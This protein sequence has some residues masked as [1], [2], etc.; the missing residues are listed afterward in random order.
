[1]QKEGSR[2]RGSF[3]FFYASIIGIF[4]PTKH[5]ILFYFQK[6]LRCKGS[7]KNAVVQ[8]FIEKSEHKKI[9]AGPMARPYPIID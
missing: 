8:V 1:M 4:L 3:R 2:Y 5:R 7:K 6:T 9:R